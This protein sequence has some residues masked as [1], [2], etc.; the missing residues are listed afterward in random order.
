MASAC[1]RAASRRR[2]RAPRAASGPR[3]PTAPAR[4]CRA[5]A[6]ER[7]APLLV[8]VH[9]HFDVRPGAEACPRAS[10]SRLDLGEVV[11]LAV[12][13]DL[14]RAVL[15]ANGCW[16][17]A[18]STIASRRIARPTPGSRMCPS[19]SGPRWCSVRTIRCTSPR[20][21]WPLEIRSTIPTMPH[22]PISPFSTLRDAAPI[23]D[24]PR[25]HPAAI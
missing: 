11:D 22:I 21:E 8:G 18:R 6:E 20:R 23:A 25:R 3:R 1:S 16:P 10:S 19:S 4:T 14:D 5:A 9:Q 15:V 17:P 13:D 7:L 12:G 2:D 24:D